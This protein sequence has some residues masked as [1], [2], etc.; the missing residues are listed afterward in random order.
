[1]IK[2]GV[3][4]I[5]TSHPKAFSGYLART[6]RGRYAAVYNDS[7]RTDA[8]VAGF[9]RMNQIEKRAGSIEE[10]AGQVD[11][12]FIQ[13]CNWD[14]HL[15]QALPFLERGKPVFIDKPIAG[16]LADCR[17]LEDL[18]AKGAVILGSSS[19]RYANEITDFL[20]IPEAEKGQI[21]NVFGTSGVDEFNYSIHIVEAIGGIAGAGA[22]SNKFVG[23]AEI[24]GKKCET[25]FTR[26]SNGITAAYN[27]FTG[28]YQPFEV[29][30]MT[31]ADTYHMRI[32]AGKVYEALLDRIFD[33]MEGKENRI[34]PLGSITESIRIMLAGKISRESGGKEVRLCD[35]PADDP[36][37]DGAQFE[38][39]YAETANKNLYL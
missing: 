2:I 38:R 24:G 9:M 14:N 15:K 35:I 17:K 16:S 5:D 19:V 12:G 31:T 22:V 13:S 27:A 1:M 25:F 6:G 36:G 34:A 4:N 30:V 20:K 11:I 23:S 32:D 37:Y 39:E 8:E 33:Y 26:F 10:M 7:F 21:L 18:V 3:V 29:V 28:T